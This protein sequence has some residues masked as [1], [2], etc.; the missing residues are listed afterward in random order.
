MVVLVAVAV[1]LLLCTVFRNSASVSVF[2]QFLLYFVSVCC[3]AVAVSKFSASLCFFG[4]MKD[5]VDFGFDGG[6]KWSEEGGMVLW[7]WG[8]DAGGKGENGVRVFC[9]YGDE[10]RE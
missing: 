8:D 5:G 9:G 3:S 10:V 4:S 7:R 6:S 2:L 1:L